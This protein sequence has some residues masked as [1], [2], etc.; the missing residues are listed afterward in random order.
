MMGLA[1]ASLICL[2]TIPL[3]LGQAQEQQAVP[4]EKSSVETSVSLPFDR[5]QYLSPEN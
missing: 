4:A 3:Q 1:L 2:D 5:A